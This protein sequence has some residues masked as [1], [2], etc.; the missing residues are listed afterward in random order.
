MGV[1]EYERHRLFTW[2]EEQ[3][4]EE[5]ASTLMDMLPPTGF[6]DL[7]TKHDLGILRQE[8]GAMESVLKQDLVAM[9]ARLT[10]K[11]IGWILASQAVTLSVIGTLISV[12]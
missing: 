11:V 6:G 8:L 7:A 12:S 9:E 1:T 3:M 4:G 2:F 10:T 5:R